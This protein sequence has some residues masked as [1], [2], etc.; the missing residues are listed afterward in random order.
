MLQEII[1]PK[2]ARCL[3]DRPLHMP[4]I[5]DEF[6]DCVIYL[7]ADEDSAQKGVRAGGSGFLVGI[8]SKLIKE[9]YHVYAVTNKHVAWTGGYSVV[10]LNRHDGKSDSIE[11][12]PDKWTIHPDGDDLAVVKLDPDRATF[13]YRRVPEGIFISPKI[14]ADHNIGPGDDCYMVGRFINHDGRQRNLPS[15]RFGNIGMMPNEP[16]RL[17]DGFLQDSFAVEMRSIGGYSGSP[18]FVH[19][20][21][22]MPR[23]DPR[24]TDK[25]QVINRLDGPW[26]LGIDWGH[27]HS[28]EPVLDKSTGLPVPTKEYVRSNSGMVG[29]VP[30]WKLRELLYLPRFKEQRMSEDQE[31]IETRGATSD[32]AHP[33]RPATADNPSQKEDFNRLLNAAAKKKPQDD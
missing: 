8:Q 15:V 6:L 14:I 20:L 28:T 9:K 29:V 11:L 1:T 22:G 23:Y 21:P 12:E 27:I 31:Q 19:I 30:A 7:Y 4:R 33:E 16:I 10:R 25:L 3:V 13:K 18:V 17:E 32:V 5:R 26:L 2:G 24:P